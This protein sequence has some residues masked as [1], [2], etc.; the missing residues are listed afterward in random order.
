MTKSRT[1]DRPARAPR[2]LSFRARLA[3]ILGQPQ[4]QRRPSFYATP[5]TPRRRHDDSRP[6]RRQPDA[7]ALFLVGVIA[8]T[9]AAAGFVMAARDAGLLN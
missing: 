6:S 1:T 7:C 2:V 3:L 8:G 4:R 5:S 9:F